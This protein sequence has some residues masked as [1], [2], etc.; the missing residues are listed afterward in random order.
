MKKDVVFKVC[1]DF[2]KDMCDVNYFL[3]KHPDYAVSMIHS[4]AV[5]S[6]GYAI[7]VCS[8]VIK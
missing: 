6:I 7:I 2:T 8:P 3:E 5:G 1:L 4:C